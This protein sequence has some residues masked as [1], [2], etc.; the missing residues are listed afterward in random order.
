MSFG[1]YLKPDEVPRK[2]SIFDQMKEKI[3]AKMAEKDLNKSPKK[4]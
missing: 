4:K 3:N 2:Q 1:N